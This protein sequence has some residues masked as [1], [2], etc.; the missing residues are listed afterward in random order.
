MITIGD[1]LIPQIERFASKYV[2]NDLTVDAF[3]TAIQMMSERADAPTGNT[4]VFVCNEKL[5]FD[6]QRVLSEWLANHTA[7][8]TEIWSQKVNGNVKVGATFNSYEVA[9]NVLTFKVDRALSREYGMD[10]GIGFMIDLTADKTS[11]APALQL[12]SLKGA[13]FIQNRVL[14]VGGA[15]GRSSGPV[16]SPVAA[17]KLIIH[18]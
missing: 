14:G 5:W 9:G 4:W 8:D 2:Y 11:G 12:M 17:T 13:D 3:T 18:G 15:D 6:I 7:C 10:K 16:S 1:G